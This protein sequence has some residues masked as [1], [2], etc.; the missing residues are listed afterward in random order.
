MLYLYVARS[1]VNDIYGVTLEKL[2]Q[3]ICKQL[4]EPREIN[5]F[6]K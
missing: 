2:V 4:R 6:Y 3:Y 5:F 1:L